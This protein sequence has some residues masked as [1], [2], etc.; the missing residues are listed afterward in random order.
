M[1]IVLLYV[2]VSMRTCNATDL[3]YVAVQACGLHLPANGGR[4]R[5]ISSAVIRRGASFIRQWSCPGQRFGRPP[6]HLCAGN[7]EHARSCRQQPFPRLSKA[8]SLSLQDVPAPRSKAGNIRSNGRK[9]VSHSVFA[10]GSGVSNGGDLD[11]SDKRWF[12]R[13]RG[14]GRV[15]SL[16]IILPLVASFTPHPV[17]LSS[18]APAAS[19]GAPTSVLLSAELVFH[20]S[21]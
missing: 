4:S 11:L 9:R 14:R 16:G 6:R 19:A 15:A 18:L 20:P 10:A 1:H 5:L 7:I 3:F 8:R 2:H 13:R 21:H 12:L 17:F